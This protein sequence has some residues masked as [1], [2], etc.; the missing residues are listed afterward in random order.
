MPF[1]ERDYAT[2]T[3]I[4]R[5]MTS[6]RLRLEPRFCSTSCGIC[7]S[8]ALLTLLAGCYGNS[9]ATKPSVP[10]NGPGVTES[11]VSGRSA[12]EQ[13]SEDLLLSILEMIQLKSL[14]FSNQ[15]D[16]VTGLLNQWQRF[17]QGNQAQPEE[18]ELDEETLESFRKVISESE[19]RQLRRYAFQ[20][21]D[22]ERLRSLALV[23]AVGL[24][25]IGSSKLEIERVTN[26]FNFLVQHT[27]LISN[28]PDD[29]PLTTY[30]LLMLGR[31]TA[32]DRAWI[33]AEVLRQLRIDTVILSKPLAKDTLEWDVT[34]PF[35]VGVLI[36]K[37]V[38]LFDPVMGLPLSVPDETPATGVLPKGMR[39]ATLA[40]VRAN[41]GIL[42]QYTVKES[43][44]PLAMD[45]IK[46]PGVFVM[47]DTAIWSGRFA[48]LQP[49]F[50]GSN[51]LLISDP[52]FTGKEGT[53]LL[54]RVATF[55]LD[56]W[57]PDQVAVCNYPETQLTG[58]QSLSAQHQQTLTRL[59]D[60]L[61][62]PVTGK[63]VATGEFEVDA[64]TG[65]K[66]AK[67]IRVASPTNLMHFARL[68]HLQG[69][70][71]DAVKGYT[72]VRFE[73]MRVP[74]VDQIKQESIE[75]L[76]FGY[77]QAAE[78]ALF[79]ISV[80]KLDQKTKADSRIA[81]DNFRQYLRIIGDGN[82]GKWREAAHAVLAQ[83][84]AGNGDLKGALEEVNQIP[85]DHPQARGFAFLKK[86]W[87]AA[88]QGVAKPMNTSDQPPPAE[89]KPASNQSADGAPANPK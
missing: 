15:V 49:A 39:V 34:Q 50:T 57:A 82:Q 87:E 78:D 67:T 2:A 72:R 83:H 14:G 81:L 36:G 26:V 54:S 23:R 10:S 9:P 64:G 5:D 22:V 77:M 61:K 62:M 85:A 79:W 3:R 6:T 43:K 86:V 41:P 88:L 69:A 7:L 46:S 52:L 89:T 1:F 48:R 84:Y 55:S 11:T 16:D 65:D 47:G 42:E 29:I 24:Y 53:G 32:L 59:T 74:E 13:Q 28:H 73:V 44:Y 37:A 45:V 35:L 20:P 19:I 30:Q 25:A 4:S 56:A 66:T 12:A 68:D 58:Q 38:Y 40:E 75:R 21:A 51:A 18:D 17:S 8:C 80:C 31:V 60:I 71:E 33:F 76:K 63:P 70:L 27:E